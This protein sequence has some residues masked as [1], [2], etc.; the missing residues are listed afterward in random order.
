MNHYNKNCCVWLICLLCFALLSGCATRPSNIT[1]A[2]TIFSENG[3]WFNNW[4][5]ESRKAEKKYGVPIPIMLAT[6]RQESGFNAK[7]KPPRRHLLGF[8]PWTR[9]SNAFGYAQVL[10]STWD[11]YKKS[12][13]NSGADRDDFGDAMNFVGWYYAIS[14]QRNG[15]ALNDAYHL[16]L[17]YYFGHGGYARGVWRNRRD[18]QHIAWRVSGYAAHYRAQMRHCGYAP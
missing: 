1:D 9:P 12:T 16:Y 5:K 17:T 15:V 18:I 2:C 8:I 11:V 6:I 7:A 14:H 13:D 10:D 3:G 4:Y